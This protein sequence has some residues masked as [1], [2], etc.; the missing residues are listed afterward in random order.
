MSGVIVLLLLAFL[1]AVGLRRMAGRLGVSA[2]TYSGVF[3]VFVLVALALFG[4]HLA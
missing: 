3:L 4:R 1:L 2:P